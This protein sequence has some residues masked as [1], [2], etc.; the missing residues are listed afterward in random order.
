MNLMNHQECDVV[1]TAVAP[2]GS[3][4]EVAGTPGAT[5]F[6]DQVKHPSWSSADAPS[7]QVGDHLHVV[8]L[9]DSRTPLRLSALQQDIEIARALREREPRE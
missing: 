2:V 5:G 4:V 8:V 9:D 7:P 3:T 1:I 6:V